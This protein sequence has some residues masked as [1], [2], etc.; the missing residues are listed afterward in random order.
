MKKDFTFVPEK[1]ELWFEK[2]GKTCGIESNFLYLRKG[3]DKKLLVNGTEYGHILIDMNTS[4]VYYLK[5]NRYRET[6]IDA[7]SFDFGTSVPFDLN[8]LVPKFKRAYDYFEELKAKYFT[9][10]EQGFKEMGFD[11]D[12]S[13]LDIKK[14]QKKLDEM[15]LV[16]F[17]GNVGGSH[18]SAEESGNKIVWNLSSFSQ[19]MGQDKQDQFLNTLVHEFTHLFIQS[20][21]TVQSNGS[22]GGYTM[23][24]EGVTE[25]IC[26]LVQYQFHGT[27]YGLMYDDR[28]Y[29][30]V[31]LMNIV[32]GQEYIEGALDH[33]YIGNVYAT[34]NEKLGKDT[35]EKMFRYYNNGNFDMDLSCG[36]WSNRLLTIRLLG[37][38]QE[39]GYDVAT[40]VSGIERYLDNKYYTGKK[41]EFLE[42][43][44][45]DPQKPIL[46]QSYSGNSL[47]GWPT[48]KPF[49]IYEDIQKWP[50]WMKQ[51]YN[52]HIWLLN[53]MDYQGYNLDHQQIALG[54]IRNVLDDFAEYW[55]GLPTSERTK[56]E[57]LNE[58]EFITK[59]AYSYM[60]RYGLMFNNV[61]SDLWSVYGT[62][63][64]ITIPENDFMVDADIGA[65][66]KKTMKIKSIEFS[67]DMTVASTK[68][69]KK[70]KWQIGTNT[71]G[72]T[73]LTYDSLSGKT[74]IGK[75]DSKIT[76]GTITIELDEPLN[77]EHHTYLP[78]GQVVHTDSG[79][80]IQIKIDKTGVTA[81]GIS[82]HVE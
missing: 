43:Y 80:T 26:N 42:K 71:Y 39:A 27:Y 29:L 60:A 44:Q 4:K 31:M 49:N 30:N 6:T 62:E 20:A 1:L 55:N 11:I 73:Q 16:V 36:D 79:S 57:H 23:D 70:T 40:L 56:L 45:L 52:K 32:G 69:G 10:L 77:Y 2:G 53:S 64:P 33:K 66:G 25:T 54:V 7:V 17:N 24:A 22:M 13:F 46:E 47:E 51:K 12:L 72:I 14:I 38:L 9:F 78:D 21:T 63:G 37:E 76:S 15:R 68:K 48:S 61:L 8:D 41:K 3:D 58:V 19:Y 5:G 65:Q 59:F 81:T 35:S 67:E 75:P 82:S 34:L 28:V 18:A 74:N 50:E